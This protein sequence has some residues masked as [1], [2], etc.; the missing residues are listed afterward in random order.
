M[1]DP[2]GEQGAA[3]RRV[4]APVTFGQGEEGA[5][6]GEALAVP[7]LVR[8]AGPV[9]PGAACDRP[10]R[11]VA[12][13]EQHA[14][15]GVVAAA[16]VGPEP[17]PRGVGVVDGQVAAVAGAVGQPDQPVPVVRG[18]H[19]VRDGPTLEQDGLVAGALQRPG[20]G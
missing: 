2:V 17:V 15:L 3:A 4:E 8:G 5:A 7:D 12:G 18:R 6:P 10:I 1:H 14:G 13:G 9:E 20:G 19:G 16:E 11:R